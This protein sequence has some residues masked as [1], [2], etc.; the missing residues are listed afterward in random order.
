MNARENPKVLTQL[1]RI[2]YGLRIS[3]KSAWHGR[4]LLETEKYNQ[5]G[6]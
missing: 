6:N 1:I 5:K 2:I 4:K 3:G